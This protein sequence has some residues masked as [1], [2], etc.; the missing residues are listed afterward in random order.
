MFVPVS[1][2]QIAS[3]YTAAGVQ[4]PGVAPGSP[5]TNKQKNNKD[6]KKAANGNAA[7]ANGTTKKKKEDDKP[8]R[9]KTIQEAVKN[10]RKCFK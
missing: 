5:S 6:G 4:M 10:V 9:P 2:S 3:V 8:K 1:N 7:S